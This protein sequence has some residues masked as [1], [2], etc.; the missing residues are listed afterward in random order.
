VI[1]ASIGKLY[2]DTKLYREI[3]SA[4][5]ASVKKRFSGSTNVSVINGKFIYV[6]KNYD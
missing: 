2:A 6:L 4:A 5:L 1:E 3:G